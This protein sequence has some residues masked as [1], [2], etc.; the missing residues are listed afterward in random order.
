[1]KAPLQR[2]VLICIRFFWVHILPSEEPSFFLIAD[3][4]DKIRIESAG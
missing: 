1:M 3:G 2:G 4:V